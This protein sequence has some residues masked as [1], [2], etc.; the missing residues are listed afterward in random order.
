ML[1]A[2]N[3]PL[4]MGKVDRTRH[5][6]FTTYRLGNV[7]IKQEVEIVPTR[8]KPGQQRRRGCSS[9]RATWEQQTGGRDRGWTGRPSA[10]G[11]V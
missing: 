3:Q 6:Y 2:Q 7:T 1:I 8:G 4:P 11:C 10:R 5:G 9:P